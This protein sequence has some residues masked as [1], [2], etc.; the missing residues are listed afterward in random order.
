MAKA[1]SKNA[2]ADA[3]PLRHLAATL[4]AALVRTA[5]WVVPIGY[6]AK[7]N[8]EAASTTGST[9]A[10]G[11]IL[12]AV[13]GAACV[14]NAWNAR[15]FSAKLLP[16]T[17]AII[18]F[19]LNFQNALSSFAAH[20][21]TSRGTLIEAQRAHSEG[22]AEV[23]QVSQDRAGQ[24]A[25]AGSA[26]P[27]AIEADIAAAKA[28]DANRWNS[29][30]HCNPELI[31]AGP[32]RTFCANLATLAAKQ[33]AARKRDELDGKLTQLRAKLEKTPA[34]ESVDS[35]ADTVAE[36]LVAAG[37]E[38]D[39]KAKKL[40][41]VLKVWGRAAGVELAGEFGPS[42]LLHAFS[43]IAGSSHGQAPAPVKARNAAVKRE[44]GEPSEV[45]AAPGSEPEPS[46]ADP[47]LDAFLAARVEFVPG[48]YVAAGPL[49]EAWQEWREQHG[50]E[51]LSQG[52]ERAQQMAFA[53]RVQLRITRESNSGRP[54]YAGIALRETSKPRFA[55]VR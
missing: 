47:E 4:G 43:H 2:K 29:T 16:A 1:T 25:I 48:S 40:I 27:E 24:A 37:Y 3:T 9:A 39:A 35:F 46:S 21:D 6:A 54:R 33:A 12:L 55:V 10:A 17:L 38:V 50:V 52:T 23:L 13:L 19:C 22:V 44:E 20:S 26:T 36:M 15:P 28:A 7:V 11:G 42:I 5:C 30:G 32:S 53:K 45:S 31:T 41:A 18:F 51:L 14:H 34:P 49:F 8:I